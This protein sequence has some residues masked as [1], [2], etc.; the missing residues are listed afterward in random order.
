MTVSLPLAMRPIIVPRELS[1]TRPFAVADGERSVT[2]RAGLSR[3]SP[4]SDEETE[5]DK[6]SAGSHKLSMPR[7]LVARMREL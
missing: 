7:H 6:D 1:W 5:Q 2:G 4:E 3:R